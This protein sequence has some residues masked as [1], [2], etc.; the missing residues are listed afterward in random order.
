MKQQKANSKFKFIAD[1]IKKSKD[2][3]FPVYCLGCEKEGVWLCDMCL[4]RIDRGGIFCCPVCHADTSGGKCCE[5]CQDKSILYSQIS[6]V[7]YLE[8]SL[9]GNL[10]A[11]LKYQYAEDVKSAIKKTIEQFMDSHQSI[12]ESVDYVVPIPLHKKRFAE[13]GYNQ[14]ELIADIVADKLG[15]PMK[16]VLLRKRATKQQAKLKRDERLSNLKNA[17]ELVEGEEV[18]GKKILLVDDVYTTGSTMGECAKVI[19]N[20][21]CHTVVGF[22]VARG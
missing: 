19:K 13:R 5:R 21:G 17:F 11:A 10:I 12:F 7:P 20:N 15:I 3:I 2:Y 18:A 22:S 16:K 6:I 14:A 8:D 4:K 1:F 9:M